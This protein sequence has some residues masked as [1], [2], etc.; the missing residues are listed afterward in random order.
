[1]FN[2]NGYLEE[3]FQAQIIL[4]LAADFIRETD[5]FWTLSQEHDLPF[6]HGKKERRS[7]NAKGDKATCVSAHTILSANI[8][9]WDFSTEKVKA[10]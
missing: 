9:R 10:Q 6:E 2:A 4:I 1:M 3:I 7:E 5:N 8:E